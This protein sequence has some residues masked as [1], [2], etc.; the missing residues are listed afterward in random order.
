MVVDSVDNFRYSV[1]F[2]LWSEV[3]HQ[4]NHRDASDHRD[5]NHKWPPRACW[6]LRVRVV[7]C[8]E[9]AKEKKIVK[10]RNEG[11]ECYGSQTGNDPNQQ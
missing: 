11:S 3:L 6:R 9:P 2:R 1:T 5:K 10:D 7:R 4:E 8:G